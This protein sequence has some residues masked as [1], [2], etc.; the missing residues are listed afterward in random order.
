MLSPGTQIGSYQVTAL[1]GAGGMGEVYRAH[2]TRLNRDVALKVLPEVFARDMQRMA[3]FEREAKLLASLN[4][5]NIAAIYGLEESGGIR[6]LVMELVEGPTLAERIRSG[7]GKAGVNS[8][9]PIE[10]ALPIAR[11]IADAVE[12]AHEQ[13]VIHRDLK[14]ANIKVKEDGTVKVLDFGLAKALSDDPLEGDMSNSP[15]L[16][17]A[18]T[19]QGVI[20]GTAAYMSPEQARGKRVDRRTDIWAFGCVFCE[21]LTGHSV[22]GGEDV[23]ETLAFVMTKEPALDALPA[24]TPPAIR[25]LLRRCLE[26]NLKRRLRDA[27]EARIVIEDVLSGAVSAEASAATTPIGR[28]ARL[29]QGYGG[30]AFPGRLGWG[31]AAVLLIATIALSAWVVVL[32][33]PPAEPQRVEFSFG[34][35]EN[36]SFNAGSSLL[37]VSPDGSKVAFV[38]IAG[39]ATPSQQLWVRTLDSETVQPL[40]GTENAS[41]PFWSADSRFLAFRADDKL[42]KIS[43][44]GGPAQTLAEIGANA[45]GG[46]WSREGV[47]LFTPGA[48]S[49]TEQTVHR[50]PATGGT[51]VPVTQLD[52]SRQEVTHTSAF[53]LPDGNH[54]LYRARSSNPENHAVYVA[55][56]DSP[57]KKLLL[58]G[59]SKVTYVSPG[60]LVFNREGTLMAQPFDAERLELTGEEVPIAEDVQFAAIGDAAFTTSEN[61]V[62]AYRT[63]TGAGASSELLWF[64]RRGKQ[65]GILGEPGSYGQVWLSPDERRVSVVV[66][67]SAT[68]T[69][70]IWIYDVAR[71]LRTRFTHEP[72]DERTS[73]WSP[74]GSRIVVNSNRKGGRF[75]LYLRPASGVGAEEVLLEDN[76]SKFPMS[77]SP[78]GRFLLYRANGLFVLPLSADRKPVPFL[79]TPFVEN[80][81][82]F[83]PDGRWVAY[84][85]DESGRN[86]IYVVPFP[87]PGG[88]TLVSTG[89]GRYGK[90]SG[91]GTEIFYLA[92]DNTLMAASVNGRGTSFEVGAVKPL[93]ETRPVIGLGP[94]HNVTAGG[95][96]FLINTLREE[97]ASAPITVVVNWQAGLRQ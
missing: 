33:Q 40:A 72:T 74:D 44:S 87:G 52:S 58:N 14:P 19:R 24:N 89:G 11:Q 67:D 25:S 46:S 43:I 82:F 70:D 95:Q 12:Y 28:L 18:A 55:S 2:D 64:D 78:D 94:P 37:A 1:I 86:E 34:P 96:R 88:K 20:L 76:F 51:P 10:E 50:V 31:V 83:S 4:H 92:L 48:A 63:A 38:G 17:M 60:Y 68:G 97:A 29:R 91:D 9:I 79:Q 90:W 61:G 57:E 56:L 53:F 73:V 32:R 80:G 15:T 47:V 54:F 13:N 66:L 84:E 81:G 93:F 6:A 71:R 85:S 16:S 22:F 21:M 59:L 30:Q 62:L 27:G 75:D 39:G 36:T 65:L 77:W 7:P 5:P 45:I 41:Q 42:K 49:G 3:R 69:R 26:R 23:S 35:P 8:A